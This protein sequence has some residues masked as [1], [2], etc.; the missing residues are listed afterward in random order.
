MDFGNIDYDEMDGDELYECACDLLN[1]GE[2]DKAVKCFELASE[3]GCLDAMVDLAKMYEHGNS[4]GK[5]F[6]E[7]LKWYK[8]AAESGDRDSIYHLGYLYYYGDEVDQ[9]YKQAYYWFDKD[10]FRDLPYYIC[11]DM[12][13]YVDQAY[14]T[15]FRFYTA[16]FEKDYY[17]GAAYKIGEMYYHGLGVAQSYENALS[18]LRYFSDEDVCEEDFEEFAAGEAPSTVNYMLSE[19][20]KNGWGVDKNL[21][22]AEKLFNAAEKS[23]WH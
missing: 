1:N 12:Y 6:D 3:N 11:A 21:E 22:L 7:S 17:E 5:D 20:Y 18:H 10:G 16:S 2:I 4:V 23:S 14:D 19:M 8:L 13:F 9:D 15:A